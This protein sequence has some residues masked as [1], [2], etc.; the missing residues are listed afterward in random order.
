M[1]A[2]Y[3]RRWPVPFTFDQPGDEAVGDVVGLGDLRE[4][5][6][7]VHIKDRDGRIRVVRVTQ[8]N[9][10]EQLCTE[11]P[12]VGDRI[13]IRFVG[14]GKK[15]KPDMSPPKLFTVE[16]RRKGSQPPNSPNSTTGEVLNASPPGA[17]K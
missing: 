8:V 10:H 15:A 11:E 1:S 7:E 16:V 14:L 13:R 4:K 6:P 3:W 5:W 2:D 17:G 9:L 12:C